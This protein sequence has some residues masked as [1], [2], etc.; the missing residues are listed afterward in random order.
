MRGQD[1]QKLARGPQ[2]IGVARRF[3]PALDEG[4]SSGRSNPSGRHTN[5]SW[6]FV[7]D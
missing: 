7:S 3:E 1:K 6:V 2:F 4:G 5:E